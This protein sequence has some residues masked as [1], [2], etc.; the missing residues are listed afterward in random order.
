MVWIDILIV[1]I[2]ALVAIVGLY[3]GFLKTM[4]GFVNSFVSFI[5]AI[6]LARPIAKLLGLIPKIGGGIAN[7][8]ST[9]FSAIGNLGEA[10]AEDTAVS[11]IISQNAGIKGFFKWIFNLVA[12]KSTISAGEVPA[13]YFGNL[14][15]SVVL[16]L[17]GF[18]VA[19]ILVRIIVAILGRLFKKLNDIKI[20]NAADKTLGFMFGAIEGFLIIGLVLLVV[21]I[22][23]FV[24]DKIGSALESTT[25]AKTFI[26]WIKNIL[27][28]I[29]SKVDLHKIVS[30]II[31]K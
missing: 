24:S 2:L 22:L 18:I 3:R 10:L 11:E 17:I 25:I 30:G 23:P 6:F 26:R 4:L 13:N 9:K 7:Y 12:G 28:F 14:V 29:S 21:S 15:G 27:E 19:F 5:I 20:V 1:V 31:K 16:I 8:F